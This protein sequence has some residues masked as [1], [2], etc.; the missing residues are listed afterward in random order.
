[1]HFEYWIDY[2]LKTRKPGPV[3]MPDRYLIEM[4]CD[5][6]AASKVYQG[7]NYSQEKPLEYLRNGHAKDLMHP[8]TARILEEWLVMLAEQGEE[9]TFSYIRSLHSHVYK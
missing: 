3:R 8:E 1:H 6:V 7:K 2:Q 4:F 5:R 9:A